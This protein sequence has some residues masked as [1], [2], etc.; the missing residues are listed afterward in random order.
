MPARPW[1]AADWTSPKL[2]EAVHR[3]DRGL[4]VVVL[5]QNVGVTIAV[6]ITCALDVPPG[7]R[8]A[9]DRTSAKLCKTIHRPDGSLAGIALP[10]NVTAKVAVKIRSSMLGGCLPKQHRG[11]Q[12]IR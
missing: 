10:E 5:P 12:T 6:E 7:S 8:I 2:S 3:P 4:P 11:G 1:I 9:A